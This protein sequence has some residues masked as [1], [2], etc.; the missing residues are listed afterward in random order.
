ML[1]PGRHGSI[2]TYR[3]GFQGQEKDDEIKGEG[4]SMNFTFRMYD[5]RIGR[6]F[7]NDPL[8]HEYPWYTPYSFAG[9]K[10]IAY[11]ELE[12]LEEYYFMDGVSGTWYKTY[13]THPDGILYQL[14]DLSNYGLY[15]EDQVVAMHRALAQQLKQNEIAVQ[16]AYYQSSVEAYND[17]V[18]LSNP[19]WM[20]FELSPFGTAASFTENMVNGDYWWAALD[21]TIG[22]VELRGLIRS[23]MFE[24]VNLSKAY[25]LLNYSFPLPEER[26]IGAVNDAIKNDILISGSVPKKSSK[27]GLTETLG[28]LSDV[29]PKNGNINCVG[30]SIAVDSNLTGREAVALGDDMAR[31]SAGLQDIANYTGSSL[32]LRYDSLDNLGKVIINQSKSKG[33]SV[34]G[35]VIAVNKNGGMSHAFNAFYKDGKVVFYD[36]QSKTLLSNQFKDTSTYSYQFY[37]T[38]E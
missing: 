16:R 28:D 36:G 21:F 37:Q 38:S 30:C 27:A 29:N 12:G 26:F 24:G 7:T 17:Y 5:S 18:R 20:A 23:K 2:D 19:V 25:K 32:G 4:N 3:Y 22:F 13:I 34:R 9:N 14:G 31:T 10:V 1:L 6:F 11:G 8:T 33:K 35:I 15:T